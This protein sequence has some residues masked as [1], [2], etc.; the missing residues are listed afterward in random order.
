MDLKIAKLGPKLLT[1]QWDT[2]YNIGSLTDIFS[3]EDWNSFVIE[4]FFCIF[5]TES[6]DSKGTCNG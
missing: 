2:L 1:Y 5:R 6:G 4:R 3:L